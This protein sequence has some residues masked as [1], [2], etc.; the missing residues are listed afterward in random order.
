MFKDV[1]YR[2]ILWMY[3]NR[4]LQIT[5]PSRSWLPNC[6]TSISKDHDY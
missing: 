6:V 2:I 5:V 4:K 1:K 3:K